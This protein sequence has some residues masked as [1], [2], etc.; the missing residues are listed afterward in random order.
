MHPQTCFIYGAIDLGI[1]T[2]LISEHATPRC[3]L[4]EV[5]SRCCCDDSRDLPH[6]LCHSTYL[7]D[8]CLTQE[9]TNLDAQCSHPALRMWW[10]EH[11]KS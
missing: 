6:S 4:V 5:R 1:R 10:R 11:G 8:S 7:H 3:E 2:R 9:A